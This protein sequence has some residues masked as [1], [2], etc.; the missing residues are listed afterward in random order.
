MPERA[1]RIPCWLCCVQDGR[2]WKLQDYGLVQASPSVRKMMSNPTKPN[3]ILM[4]ATII[5]CEYKI[6][7]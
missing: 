7:C 3:V 5:F 4:S 1:R 2:I 6:E